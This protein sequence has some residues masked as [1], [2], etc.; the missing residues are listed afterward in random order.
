MTPTLEVCEQV[1]PSHGDAGEALGA[2]LACAADNRPRYALRHQLRTM[3]I[4]GVMC[5]FMQGLGE[6]YFGAYGLAMGLGQVAAGL[7]STMPLL[8]G[9]LLQL[10]SPHAVSWLRS[11]RRWVVFC[12]GAQASCFLPLAFGSVTE[13][14]PALLIFAVVAV[15]WGTGLASGPAWSTWAASI[16]PVRLRAR[17]FGL[18]TRLSQGALLIGFLTS[19]VTLQLAAINGCVREAFLALFTLAAVC[20]FAS[21]SLLAGQAE[22]PGRADRTQL[23]PYRELVR[24]MFGRGEGRVLLYLVAM[25]GAVQL[26]GPYFTPF[27]LKQ[28][29]LSYGMYVLLVGTTYIAKMIAA[30]RWGRIAQRHGPRRLLWIGGV[31]I[32]PVAGLWLVSQSFVYLMCVQMISGVFWAAYELAMLLLLFDSVREEERVSVLTVY[33]LASAVATAGGSL[34]GGFVLTTLGQS[35]DAYLALFGISSATRA[36]MLLLVLRLPGGR[37][38]QAATTNEAVDADNSLSGADWASSARVLRIDEAESPLPGQHDPSIEGTLPVSEL[39]IAS[40]PF[41]RRNDAQ[42]PVP[43]PP[44]DSRQRL[45]A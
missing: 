18:R 34:L 22:E 33:N 5:S 4:E 37:A 10:V 12:V 43:F 11:H 40:V 2:Y 39:D 30:P 13:S 45:S 14:V 27:M 38:L 17:F 31:G 21:G 41:E 9:A 42:I 15:Y 26:S 19:G 25:Q 7:L 24:R 32:V 28:L 35:Y 16:V 36:L 3:H 29:Q 6:L 1:A 20:R 23:V 44:L 8:A